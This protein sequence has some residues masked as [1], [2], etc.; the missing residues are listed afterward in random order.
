ML[1]ER[2]LY[3][4]SNG[5]SWSLCRDSHNRVFVLHRVNVPAGGANEIIELSDF[6]RLDRSGPEH[7]ALRQL[8]GSLTD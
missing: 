4:S 8:I 6:L 3:S 2:K 5:D 1:K 7:Q